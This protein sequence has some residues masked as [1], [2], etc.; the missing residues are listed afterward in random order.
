MILTGRLQNEYE[1]ITT[2]IWGDGGM[3]E[4]RLL[5]LCLLGN[6]N[7]ICIYIRSNIYFQIEIKKRQFWLYFKVINSLTLGLL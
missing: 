7:F 5:K 2:F 6:E 4:A 1:A 3:G